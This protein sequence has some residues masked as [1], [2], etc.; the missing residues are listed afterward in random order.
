V[1]EKIIVLSRRVTKGI[2]SQSVL[3]STVHITSTVNR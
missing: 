1:N 3:V 2:L